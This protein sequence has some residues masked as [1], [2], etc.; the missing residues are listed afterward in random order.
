MVGAGVVGAVEVGFGA[1]VGAEVE[2]F[3]ADVVGLLDGVVGAVLL[4]F[5]TGLLL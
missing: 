2:G 5:G 1:V 4:G 3:G